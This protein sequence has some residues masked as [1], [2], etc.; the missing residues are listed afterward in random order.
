MDYGQAQA[1]QSDLDGITDSWWNLLNR[2]NVATFNKRN[3][4]TG[5]TERLLDYALATTLPDTKIKCTVEDP[6]QLL[7][8]DTEHSA[9]LLSVTTDSGRQQQRKQ[10]LQNDPPPPPQ[11]PHA[12]DSQLQTRYQQL[13]LS[14][15]A[16]T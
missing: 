10:G 15:P 2:P 11:Q 6:E 12:Q 4:N 7:R 9:L 3:R 1:L 14:I 8:V 13:S 16:P 5:I